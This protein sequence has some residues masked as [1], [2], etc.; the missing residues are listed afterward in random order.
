MIDDLFVA[1]TASFYVSARNLTD[2]GIRTL[3]TDIR[4]AQENSGNAIFRHERE[5]LGDARWSALCFLYDGTPAF[6]D[7][8]TDVRER[9]CG[10]VLVVEYGGYVAIFS[11]RVSVPSKFKTEY[12]AHIPA[13]RVEAAIAKQDA[14]FSKL[15]MRNM[16]VSRYAMRSKTLEAADLANV[17]GPAGSRR[18]A[19]QAYSVVVDGLHATATPST[20]R[21]AYRSDRVGHGE[22]IDFA[23]VVIDGLGN[24]NAPVSA[25]LRTFARP[26]ALSDA[27]RDSNPTTLAIDT[28]SLLEDV[29]GE[30]PAFRLIRGND[31]RIAITEIELQQ[32]IEA[33]E[34]PLEIRGDGKIREAYAPQSHDPTATISLN[35]GRIALRSLTVADGIEVESTSYPLGQDPDVRPL[36]NFIDDYD[37]FLVLFADIRLAYIGGT[38]FRDETLVDGGSAFLKRLHSQQA[39]IGVTSEKGNFSATHTAFDSDSTFGVIVDH[40]AANDEILVCDD[41]GDEWADFIGLKNVGLPQ[42]SFYHGKHGDLSL[43]ASAFH[44]SVSQ[45]IKNLGNMS[46]PAD[47]MNAKVQGWTADYANNNHV[48]RIPR[49]VRGNVPTLAADLGQTRTAP[50]AIRRAVIVTSSLSRQAV[51]DVLAGAQVGQAPSPA[52]VQLYWLLQS[53]FSDC[54][55]AGVT[56]S[57]VCRP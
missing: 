28:A 45:A 37:E 11:S 3:F 7:P 42:I 10:Y 48:T 25:F 50:E 13:G 49:I 34:Q 57:I 33:L 8:T 41:L 51:A 56:G 38:V 43:G 55:E 2:K 24:S 18:Y 35:K 36:R 29:A 26:I 39:L 44:V 21:I 6:L 20:G 46:F 15:R 32:L 27:L 4:D 47:R 23:K 17:V 40:V 9:L 30:E 19:P 53:F 52:F 16:S 31:N 22:L 14:V 1:K 54:N 5:H 12:L